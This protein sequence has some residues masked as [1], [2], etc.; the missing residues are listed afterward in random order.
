M[1]E[2]EQSVSSAEHNAHWRTLGGYEFDSDSFITAMPYFY[3]GGG[4][5]GPTRGAR[6]WT[7][8]PT[9]Q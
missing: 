4:H 8:L 5:S 7:P 2:T 6:D 9:G 3:R 1:E